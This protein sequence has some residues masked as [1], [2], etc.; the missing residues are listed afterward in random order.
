[1]TTI[2]VLC[3]MIL[4]RALAGNG[5]S[6]RAPWSDC[7]NGSDGKFCCQYMQALSGAI[8]NIMLATGLIKFHDDD[9]ARPDDAGIGAM[10]N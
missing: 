5:C 1:M 3:T 7:T 8:N 4:R 6:F 9:E 10:S 2:L